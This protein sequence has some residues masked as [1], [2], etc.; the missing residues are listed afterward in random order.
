MTPVP[1]V[2]GKAN[3]KNHTIACT[4]GP[5]HTTTQERTSGSVER[6]AGAGFPQGR[7]DGGMRESINTRVL[8]GVLLALGLA[9]LC[10]PTLATAEGE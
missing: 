2:V 3:M 6:C 4:D 7:R 1:Q 8:P 10:L 5:A 9:L